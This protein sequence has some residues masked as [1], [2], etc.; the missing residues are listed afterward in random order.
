MTTRSITL[1]LTEEEIH[2]LVEYAVNQI[3]ADYI[4]QKQ[5]PAL[6]KSKE[7]WRDN[8]NPC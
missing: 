4:K 2:F 5:V 7:E 1:N 6:L 3:L 8:Y